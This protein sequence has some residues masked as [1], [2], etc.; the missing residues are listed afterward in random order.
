MQ[1]LTSLDEKRVKTLCKSG[2]GEVTCSF[3]VADSTGMCCSK[4]SVF[5]QA[6]LERRSTMGSK[7]D[8]CSGP[9]D[10]TPNIDPMAK[11]S[12]NMSNFELWKEIAGRKDLVGG[13]VESIEDGN[14]YRGP[15]KN[16]KVT[17]QCVHFETEWSATR[18]KGSKEWVKH[19]IDGF[20]V[21][22]NRTRPLIDSD[23]VVHFSMMFLGPVTIFPKGTHNL[24][25][26]GVKGLRFQWKATVVE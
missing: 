9:P 1:G 12:T 24:D 11:T 5:E 15:I 25:P 23:G 16:I 2:Q 3:L 22:I 19:N 8:N 7:A 26:A 21:D 13:D 6:I 4:G 10:F 18:S 20:V 17:D 14:Y